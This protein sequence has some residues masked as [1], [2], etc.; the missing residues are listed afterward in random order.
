MEQIRKRPTAQTIS[1]TSLSLA[2]IT[3][4]A[5]WGGMVLLLTDPQGLHLPLPLS[6]PRGLLVSM[7]LFWLPICTGT[8]ACLTGLAGLSAGGSMDVQRRAVVGILLGLAPACLA[9][10]WIGW[11]LINSIR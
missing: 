2:L 7:L 8:V 6:T 11:M 1:G 10:L 3:F 4:L 9:V 5:M